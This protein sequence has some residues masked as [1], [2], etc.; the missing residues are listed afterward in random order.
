MIATFLHLFLPPFAY[1]LI[2]FLSL[3]HL[4]DA[5]FPDSFQVLQ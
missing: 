3:N 2:V 4:N 1:L 5:L